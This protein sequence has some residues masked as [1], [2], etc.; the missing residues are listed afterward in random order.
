MRQS[1]VMRIPARW[2]RVANVVLLSAAAFALM[3][4]AA[5]R[6]LAAGY[7]NL[8]M[9][10]YRDQVVARQ[11]PWALDFPYSGL[12]QNTLPGYHLSSLADRVIAL[13]GS[14]GNAQWFGG[15]SAL[16]NGDYKKAARILENP[17]APNNPFLYEVAILA[18]TGAGQSIQA[19]HLYQKIPAKMR[20]G[21]VIEA[22]AIANLSHARDLIR[23]GDRRD[24]TSYLQEALESRP[25][26]LYANTH[27]LQSTASDSLTRSHFEGRLRHFPIEAILVTEDL[28][29]PLVNEAIITLYQTGAW[30]QSAVVHVVELMIWTRPDNDSVQELVGALRSSNPI[31][32][33]WQS[34]SDELKV[35]RARH[36]ELGAKSV[37]SGSSDSPSLDEKDGEREGAIA[38]RSLGP[39]L[40]VDGGFESVSGGEFVHWRVSDYAN[41]LAPGHPTAAFVAGPDAAVRVNGDYSAR[42]DGLW[43]GGDATPGFYGFVSFDPGHHGSYALPLLPGREYSLMG[44]YRTAGST[45][46]PNLYLGNEDGSI[47]DASLDPTEGQWRLFAL[48]VCSNAPTS[49]QVQF[50][51]RL[52]SDGQVWFDD[53]QFQEVQTTAGASFAQ[54]CQ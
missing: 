5:P 24:A 27:M 42:I 33:S 52:W 31:E 15:R 43:K 37:L 34:L 1:I 38:Q 23:D 4:I 10:T 8:G 20:T 50:L 17:L 30:T 6:L 2:H 53:L 11:E 13:T 25:F 32:P 28:L 12:L 26:D 49:S 14:T 9:I 36:L 39:N 18:A 40:L 44:A 48:P 35:R 29:L 21:R 45:E 16:T 51:L 7:T 3:V 41:G 22:F 54:T 46:I 47:L 19:I